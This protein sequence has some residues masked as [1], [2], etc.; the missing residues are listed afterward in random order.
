MILF[1]CY[2]FPPFAVLLMRRPFSAV[3]NCFFTMFGWVPGVKHAL[4]LFADYR[5]NGHVNTIAG[6]INRPAYT[7][8]SNAQGEA[9]ARGRRKEI[10]VVVYDNPH[11]GKNGTYFRAKN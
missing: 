8:T 4:V 6:A 1:F 9:R 2:V 10:E 5:V 11:V 7:R 3:L